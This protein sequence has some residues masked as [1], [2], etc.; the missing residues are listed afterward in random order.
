MLKTANIS[1]YPSV[2]ARATASFSVLS[3]TINTIR[4]ILDKK[5]GRND[6]VKHIATLQKEEEKKLRLT[7][8]LHLD[9]M[10]ERNEKLGGGGD[11]KVGR[12]LETGVETLKTQVAQCAEAITDALDEIRCILLDENEEE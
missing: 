11:T 1:E 5:H 6:I 9:R 10:R 4:S 12:L 8:A 3:D 7:A 2:C